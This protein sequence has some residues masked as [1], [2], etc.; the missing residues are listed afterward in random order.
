M[1]AGSPRGY[2]ITAPGSPIS[3]SGIHARTAISL[4]WYA[5]SVATRRPARSHGAQHHCV[6]AIQ[7]VHTQAWLLDRSICQCQSSAGQPC[8]CCR[9]ACQH[10]Q[11]VCAALWACTVL[12]S[13]S[14]RLSKELVQAELATSRAVCCLCCIR[15]R[16]FPTIKP[17][18]SCGKA[19]MHS[20]V[21]YNDGKGCMHSTAAVWRGANRVTSLGKPPAVGHA[22]YV[23]RS[24]VLRT[25]THTFTPYSWASGCQPPTE[26]PAAA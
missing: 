7:A 9:H 19:Y 26:C 6:V 23:R 14:A 5:A 21:Q 12:R 11:L 2:D 25:C 16:K 24:V 22:W 8:S 18:W 13:A 10:Q 17:C 15:L 1:P 3:C 4:A 20:S